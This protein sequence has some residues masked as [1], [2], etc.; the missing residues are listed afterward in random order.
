MHD[1]LDNTIHTGNFQSDA[2]GAYANLARIFSV[3]ELSRL[4][5]AYQTSADLGGISEHGTK[6]IKGASFNPRPGRICQILFKDCGETNCH[7]FEAAILACGD[8]PDDYSSEILN[9]AKDA[10]SFASAPA[11]QYSLAAERIGLVLHL[12]QIRHLHML[13]AGDDIKQGMLDLAMLALDC[14]TTYPENSCARLMLETS[15]G[16]YGRRKKQ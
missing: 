14:A 8:L 11:K 5:R 7:V 13:E 4:S 6:R 10:K 2:P 9:I 1:H 15:I 3:D 16:H 12:D